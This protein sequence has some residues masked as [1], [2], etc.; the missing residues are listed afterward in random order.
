MKKSIYLAFLLGLITFNPTQKAFATNFPVIREGETYELIIKPNYPPLPYRKIVNAKTAA[1]YIY[2]FKEKIP[3]PT[4]IGVPSAISEL[5]VKPIQGSFTE[6][7]P[8]P[9]PQ[10]NPSPN[11]SPAPVP[12]PAPMIKPAPAPAPQA[13]AVPM[14]N[15]Q[16]VCPT[17]DKSSP[18]GQQNDRYLEDFI[19]E[20]GKKINEEKIDN[21]MEKTARS[22][23]RSSV[24]GQLYEWNGY[25]RSHTSK[26]LLKEQLTS[27]FGSSTNNKLRWVRMDR[28]DKSIKNPDGTFKH[29][30]FSE[31]GGNTCEYRLI[32]TGL[33]GT[34]YQYSF[35]TLYPR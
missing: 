14:E 11:P 8:E 35:L 28:N 16:L 3:I 21:Q 18:E 12:S 31:N 29:R 10:P 25:I 24:R 32:E 30:Y 2:W 26:S 6:S 23:L 13:Q 27:W 5:S 20:V 34:V 15:G 1:E 7:A 4:S 33:I 9:A 19:V 17:F 22:V